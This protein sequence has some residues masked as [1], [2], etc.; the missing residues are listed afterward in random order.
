MWVQCRGAESTHA[1]LQVGQLLSL[2]VGYYPRQFATT[3]IDVDFLTE[4][5]EVD[6]ILEQEVEECLQGYGHSVASSTQIC[7]SC[8]ENVLFLHSIGMLGESVH[9]L[10]HHIHACFTIGLSPVHRSYASLIG[11][12]IW[13]E[14]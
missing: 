12:L 3:L 7:G 6:G 13:L 10:L 4:T 5:V 1:S 11:V 8:T 14:V 2:T 9:P